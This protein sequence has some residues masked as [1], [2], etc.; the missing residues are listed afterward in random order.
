MIFLFLFQTDN[1]LFDYQIDMSNDN[2][3]AALGRKYFD[4]NQNG[5][6]YVKKSLYNTNITNFNVSI[7]LDLI[8]IIK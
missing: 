2:A 6:L 5:V 1:A 4:I 3:N 8:S 7:V